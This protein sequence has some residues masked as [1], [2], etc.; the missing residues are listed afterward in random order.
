METRIGLAVTTTPNRSDV[1]NKWINSYNEI[2]PNLPLYIHN[3]WLYKG[4]CYSKNRCLSALYDINCDFFMLFDDD[5]I[6]KNQYFADKYINS[7]LNHACYTFSRQ[8]LKQHESYTEYVDPNG[9]MLFFK[10]ICLDAVGGWDTSYT[11][12][13]YEHSDFSS[14]IFNAGLTPARFI[15]IPNSK[16]LFEMAK[17]QSSFSSKDRMQIP[18]NYKLYQQ[19]YYSK[20]FKPFK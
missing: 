13:G 10:R 3:D 16:G 17:C 9:C 8:L 7:G 6:I 1:F 19:N 20:E 14:R 2:C 12:F 18:T 5:C 11:G 15:D 4:V